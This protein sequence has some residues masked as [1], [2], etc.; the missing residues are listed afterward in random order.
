MQV[1]SVESLRN[2]IISLILRWTFI[3]YSLLQWHSP[4][5]LAY[6]PLKVL[7]T[8]VTSKI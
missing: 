7:S 1:D 3:F 8:K 6:K 5:L 2:F 4:A